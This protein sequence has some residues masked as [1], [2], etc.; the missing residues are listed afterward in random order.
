MQGC[1]RNPGT[2]ST[3]AISK[4]GRP[5]IDQAP[6]D[7][8]GVHREEKSYA[9]LEYNFFMFTF[10]EL[11][12]FSRVREEYFDDDGFAAFQLNLALNPQDLAETKGVD[13]PCLN[14]LKCKCLR[15]TPNVT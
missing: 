15:V 9:P 4:I 5:R 1:K 13:R 7:F 6:A 2:P 10:I 12:S 11:T 8:G 14:R 3:S